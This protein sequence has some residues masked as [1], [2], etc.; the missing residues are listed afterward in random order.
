[1]NG[2]HVGYRWQVYRIGSDERATLL[3]MEVV[4]DPTDK[5]LAKAKAQAETYL[6]NNTF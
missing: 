6:T 5:G 2:P 1:M 4:N 3:H